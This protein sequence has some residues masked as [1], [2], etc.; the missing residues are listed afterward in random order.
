MDIVPTVITLLVAVAISAWASY[1][2]G[3]PFDPMKPRLVPYTGL[4]FVAAVVAVY[5]VVHLVNLAG[6]ETGRR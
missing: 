1:K 6:F 5:M 3:Q 2:A 4:I